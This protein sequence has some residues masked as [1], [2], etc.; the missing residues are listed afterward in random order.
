MNGNAIKQV[1]FSIQT[2]LAW[3]FMLTPAIA[4]SESVSC[5]KKRKQ[6]LAEIRHAEM[7]FAAAAQEMPTRDAFL[8]F[9]APNSILFRPGPVD[10]RTYMEGVTPG[11]GTLEW[12]PR[13]VDIS[14]SGDLGFTFGPWVSRDA[15][16][17]AAGWG[18]YISMWKRQPDGS[19]KV[20]LDTGTVFPE[21]DEPAASERLV[22]AID[23]STSLLDVDV[24]TLMHWDSAKGG[25]IHQGNS[26]ARIFRMGKPSH[27]QS[28][29]T[30]VP[31]ENLGW[32]PAG[33]GI[34][35]SN[36]I[37]YSYGTL[38]TDDGELAESY[39]HIWRCCVDSEW[40]MLVD[41]HVGQ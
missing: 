15:E 37:G 31:E 8:K 29:E 4:T 27:R 28:A 24:E 20:E 33:A 9:L 22:R 40:V 5:D 12:G 36:D 3:L 25:A 34:S 2:L 1:S 16:G 32:N 11:S 41:V 35:D 39:L 13:H 18:E 14:A 23:S 38:Q 19:L 21:P 26:A 17:V 10:G 6:Q 30:P 7:S